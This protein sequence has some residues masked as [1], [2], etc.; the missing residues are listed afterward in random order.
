MLLKISKKLNEIL[1]K[2]KNLEKEKEILFGEA[3]NSFSKKILISQLKFA[4]N[5]QW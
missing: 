1:I 4:T 3:Y 2:Y 5:S